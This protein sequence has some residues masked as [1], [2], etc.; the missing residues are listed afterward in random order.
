MKTWNAIFNIIA[1]LLIALMIMMFGKIKD[2]NERQF[3]EVRLSQAIDYA[4]GAAFRAAISTDTIG[5][6]Y[7]DGGLEEVKVN[8]TLIL[9][10]F[11]NVL[12]LS[13]DMST[14]EENFQNIESSIATAVLCGVDGYYI[15]ENMEV[16]NYTDD[17]VVGQEMG[18]K[19]GLKRPYIVY[20]SDGSRLFAANLVNTKTIEY[21]KPDE[22]RQI[23]GE[24]SKTYSPALEYR[25]TLED[26]DLT[27]DM[28]KQAISQL[29]T[30]DITRAIHARNIDNSGKYINSFFLPASDSMTAVNNIK[31]PSLIV[32]FQDSSFL[33][34][35]DMD[36]MSVGGTRVKV[37]T[38]VLGFEDKETGELCY[39]YAGQQV[40]DEDKIRIK[41][42]FNTVHEAAL[43]GYSPHLVFLSRELSK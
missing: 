40:G 34:G 13:Y 19:W 38:S 18:L 28:V 17:V 1:V 23:G 27:E 29:I 30:E 41:E 25:D 6:D 43:A 31:S 42:R 33:N 7:I 4:T 21:V 11:C 16:D 36:V 2:T 24:T 37:I 9:D 35:Y 20:N 10:T 22:R 3:E 8:P 15:L 32:L 26:T 39:C 14:G 12:C 5:T